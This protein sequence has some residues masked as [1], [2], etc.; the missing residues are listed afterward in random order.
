VALALN[1]SVFSLGQAMG[2]TLGGVALGRLRRAGDPGGG[3][4]DVGRRLQ[5]AQ[6]RVPAGGAGG[7]R[8]AGA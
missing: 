7:G 3:A 8:R 6:L 2:A 5:R 1:G 4:D